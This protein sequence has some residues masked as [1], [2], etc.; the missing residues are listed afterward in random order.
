MVEFRAFEFNL[1]LKSGFEEERKRSR[2]R[3]REREREKERERE[4]NLMRSSNFCSYK[5][6]ESL[7][8]GLTNIVT[9]SRKVQFKKWIRFQFFG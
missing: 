3:E 5:C 6:S 1:D 8:D 2:E 4:R 7:R 9:E